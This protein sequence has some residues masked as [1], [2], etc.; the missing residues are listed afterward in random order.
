MKDKKPKITI[1]VSIKSNYEETN[2]V[3]TLK[4][5]IRKLFKAYQYHFSTDEKQILPIE[6]KLVETKTE[7]SVLKDLH[8]E[9]T[10]Y[11]MDFD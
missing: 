8:L 5:D 3:S 10:M 9:Q 4:N 6:L 7:I 2:I 11:L 1:Q